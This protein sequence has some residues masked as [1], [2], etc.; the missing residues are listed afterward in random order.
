MLPSAGTVAK[1]LET[2]YWQFC[3]GLPQDPADLK[4]KIDL[5]G[6]AY[7]H[8]M[9]RTAYEGMAVALPTADHPFSGIMNAAPKVVFS[10]TLKTAEWANTTIAAGETTEEIDKLRRGGDGHIVVW[11]GVGLWRSLVR[12]D[13]IDEF[14]LDLHPYVAGEGTRLFDDVPK[15]YRLDLVSSIEFSNGTVGL[16]YRRHRR[17]S[18]SAQRVP[19]RR[20][21]GERWS[22]RGGPKKE[23]S[24][25][26]DSALVVRGHGEWCI[27]HCRR[28]KGMAMSSVA[29]SRHVT[30]EHASPWLTGTLARTTVSVGVVAAAVTT[31]GAVGLRAA[32]VPLAVDGRIPLAGFAQVTFVA[33]VIGGVLVA[34]LN[35]RSSAPRRRFVQVTI[36]LT[37]ISC[38]APAAFADTTASRVA[39]VGLHLVAAAIIV[40]ALARHAD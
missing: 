16:R 10:R 22:A 2:E 11:G 20:L 35:R 23:C 18:Q 30:A 26:V 29:T 21:G 34:L 27:G 14:R 33:A 12:L 32:G 15:S 36:G 8:I 9:G 6:S 28:T 39:L 37:A 24:F 1:R 17:V 4:Q 25:G 7:A 38:A 13:L 3:F 40:P 5:Y 31:V 19:D